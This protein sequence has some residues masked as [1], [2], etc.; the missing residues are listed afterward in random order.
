M[1]GYIYLVTSE[2]ISVFNSGFW[3]ADLHT[4]W[5]RY[6]GYYGPHVEFTIF[7]CDDDNARLFETLVHTAL[8]QYRYAFE[9]FQKSDEAIQ[10]FQKTA[11]SLCKSS[12]ARPVRSP[13]YKKKPRALSIRLAK[14]LMGVSIPNN[15]VP[16][17]AITEKSQDDEDDIDEQVWQQRK[18]L[19]Q[20]LVVSGR[21]VAADNQ[22]R[23]FDGIMLDKTHAQWLL[24][25]IASDSTRNVLPEHLA[26]MFPGYNINHN[27]IHAVCERLRLIL[28]LRSLHDRNSSISRE[29][30]ITHLDEIVATVAEARELIGKP[31]RPSRAK[32]AL[33]AQ[34]TLN[35][36]ISSINVILSVWSGTA[37]HNTEK[38]KRIT[39]QGER[40]RAGNYQLVYCDDFAHTLYSSGLFTA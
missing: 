34:P 21:A 4:L 28:G 32:T 11:A 15:P 12:V 16:F 13:I 5:Q 3:T 29:K 39:K 2:I 27:A 1:P 37:L 25:S 24:T 17:T 18:Y 31:A 20:Q 33:P 10:V 30:I 36:V 35:Q 26:L 22:S 7:Q 38:D 40:N 9:L 8:R 19:F 23:L 6:A 14:E